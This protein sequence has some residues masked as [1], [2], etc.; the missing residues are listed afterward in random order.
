VQKCGPYDA[1]LIDGDH[2]YEGV[3]KDWQAYG[4]MARIVAFH[5][6]VGTGQKENVTGRVVEVPIL[7]QEIRD[8]G[9]YKTVE[10]VAP[11]S[12]MGIG[13]VLS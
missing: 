1:I 3:R 13:V 2:T 10:F 9:K 7:W 4:G 6:I 12:K 5:D 8:S 11:R